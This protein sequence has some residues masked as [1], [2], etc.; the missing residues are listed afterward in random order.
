VIP[1][2]KYSFIKVHSVGKRFVIN[3]LLKCGAIFLLTLGL[4]E[5]AYSN[6]IDPT[7]HPAVTFTDQQVSSD[8]LF[9]LQ[10][11]IEEEDGVFLSTKDVFDNDFKGA[12][13]IDLSQKK[14]F[15]IQTQKYYWFNIKIED[16]EDLSDK[17]IQVYR[18]GNCHIWE[19]TYYEIVA[20]QSQSG[21]IKQVALSGNHIPASQRDVPSILT[22]TTLSLKNWNP[23]EAIWIKIRTVE[24][25]NLYLSMKMKTDTEV[26]S[27]RILNQKNT[28]NLL[29]CGAITTIFFI[30]LLLF[31]KYREDIY[32]WFIIYLFSSLINRL[33]LTFPNDI[34]YLFFPENPRGFILLFSIVVTLVFGSMLQFWRLYVNL[35]NDHP[36]I[37]RYIGYIIYI[38][39]ATAIF[40]TSAKHFDLGFD[41]W[42]QFRAF[43]YLIIFISIV[44]TSVYLVIKGSMLARV[45]SIG[46]GSVSLFTIIGLIMININQKLKAADFTNIV[47]IGFIS[48]M[49]TAIIYRFIMVNDQ[50][51]NMLREKITAEQ[52]NAEQL[53]R[54]NTASNKFVPNAFLNFLGRKNI[55]NATLGDSKEKEVAILFSDLRNFTS[56]S[57]NLSPKETFKYISNF[58]KGIGPIVTRHNGFINQYLGDGLMVVFPDAPQD[59]LNAALDMKAFQEQY[60]NAQK[61]ANNIDTNIGIGIH[62]GKIIMG[63]MGDEKRLDATIISDTVNVAARIEEQTKKYSSP[64]L[65]SK[66]FYQKLK[67]TSDYTIRSLGQTKLKGKTSSISI[68]QC[69]DYL[70]DEH[71]Q[72]IKK[73]QD[74]FHQA[75]NQIEIGNHQTGVDLLTKIIEENPTDKSS[76]ALLKIHQ[77]KL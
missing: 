50:K 17:Y 45:I 49:V 38:F 46:I 77:D 34:F 6:Q 15:N 76:V 41:T 32:I 44:C 37:Y 59:A 42:F 8:F 67:S 23:S 24:S 69:L 22:P 20:Y 61:N 51:E 47:G 29:I 56:I 43:I 5:L 11:I 30:T 52:L 60:H 62:Y 25:C 31:F 53:E 58:N 63:I 33:I 9:D 35:F 73:Y 19:L 48:V 74:I 26:L 16:I 66:T 27:T 18:A 13:F 40:N 14:D 28:F 2:I 12:R 3:A 75:M 71:L 65:F 57:E 68:F 4:A 54:I 1:L 70:D 72:L 55:L 64:I 7:L 39:L 10:W 21:V 36:A